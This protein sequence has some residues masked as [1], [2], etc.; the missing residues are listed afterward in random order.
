MNHLQHLLLKLSEECNEVGQMSSKCM[1]FGLLESHPDLLENNKQRLHAELNDLLAI[2][3]MLNAHFNFDYTP[4]QIQIGRKI[5]K[6]NKYLAY[7]VELGCVS[8]NVPND[9][10][11][12]GERN[13]ESE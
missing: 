6:V 9:Q 1:Q 2:V 13:N 11:K 10:W 12:Y 4:N 7:S 8:M 3:D 5:E